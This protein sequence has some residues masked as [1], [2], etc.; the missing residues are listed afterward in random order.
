M[1]KIN[2][3]PRISHEFEKA[4]FA[5]FKERFSFKAQNKIYLNELVINNASFSFFERF[6]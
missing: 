6:R 1:G 5:N 4:F 3:I 2:T